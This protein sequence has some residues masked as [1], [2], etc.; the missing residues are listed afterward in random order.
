M[1]SQNKALTNQ[2]DVAAILIHIL[3]ESLEIKMVM[4]S[5]R[6]KGLTPKK[7]RLLKNKI[8][9]Y[10]QSSHFYVNLIKK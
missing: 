8:E 10:E 6:I 2:V 7:L 4:L 3:H 9:S 1:E 5:P